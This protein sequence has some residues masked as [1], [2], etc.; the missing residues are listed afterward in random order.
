[1]TVFFYIYCLPW[2]VHFSL[3]LQLRLL[4]TVKMLELPQ[5]CDLTPS[6]KKARVHIL[7]EDKSSYPEMY[8]WPFEKILNYARLFPTP[9]TEESE[10]RF[11]C[12]NWAQRYNCY[13]D[14]AV[15]FTEGDYDA[16]LMRIPKTRGMYYGA[17]RNTPAATEATLCRT[18][19]TFPT[20]VL[21]D[22]STQ[23]TAA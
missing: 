8:Q 15:P 17:H 11:G 16:D 20:R 14:W 5:V 21:C 6:E 9:P 3:L 23:R 18:V 10:R 22:T 4:F 12:S 19:R 7:P 1:M 13:S 2:K